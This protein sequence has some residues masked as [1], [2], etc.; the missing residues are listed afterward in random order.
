MLHATSENAAKAKALASEAHAVAAAGSV[1]MTEMMAAMAAIDTSSNEVA[2]IVK[3]IDQL[4][5]QTNILALNAAVEAA[6]AGE[7]GAGFAVVADEVRALAQRS[8]AAAR[9]TAAKIEVAI[10]NT[11]NG[12][13]CSTRVGEALAKIAEKVTSTDELVGDIARAAK[14]QALGIGQINAAISQMEKVTQSNAASAEESASAAEELDAQAESVHEL[15]GTL[16]LLV[17]SQNGEPSSASRIAPPR[18]T[19]APEARAGAAR[20]HIP[21]PGDPVARSGEDRHFRDF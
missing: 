8:A 11:R 2:K 14:E 18:R 4:A 5:F 7:A 9:E 12:S 15:V 13:A 1:T 17:G 19:R 16:R 3:E 10:S 20:T 6:R 21:M